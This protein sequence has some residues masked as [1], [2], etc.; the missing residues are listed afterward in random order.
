MQNWQVPPQYTDSHLYN[1]GIVLQNIYTHTLKHNI[2]KR[3]AFRQG[4]DAPRDCVGQRHDNRNGV[5]TF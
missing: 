2:Y 5:K 1:P 3:L 4:G